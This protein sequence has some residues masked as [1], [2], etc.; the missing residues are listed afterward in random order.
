MN[1]YRQKCVVLITKLMINNNSSKLMLKNDFNKLMI[2]NNKV[3]PNANTSSI[4][5]QMQFSKVFICKIIIKELT[6]WC[7]S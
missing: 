5:M 7:I 4:S 3:I 1:F 6:T 2:N